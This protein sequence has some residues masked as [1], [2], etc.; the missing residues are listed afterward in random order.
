MVY[1][2]QGREGV[3][4]PVF[5]CQSLINMSLNKNKHDTSKQRRL[6]AQQQAGRG[7]PGRIYRLLLALHQT[8]HLQLPGTTTQNLNISENFQGK[9][10][11][12]DP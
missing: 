1:R 3:K 2:Y 12:T 6:S 8:F 11:T 4:L 10:H 5:D 9:G 7:Y